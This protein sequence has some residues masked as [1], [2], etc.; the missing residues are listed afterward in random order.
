MLGN[1]RDQLVVA[2]LFVGRHLL[3]VATQEAVA[4]GARVSAVETALM[5]ALMAFP[6][7]SQTD[8]VRIVGRDKTTLSRTIARL[9]KEGMITDR[10][11][12]V[13]G[14]RKT[15][16]L[17]EQARNLVVPALHAVSERLE[18][19][20]SDLSSEQESAF[21]KMVDALMKS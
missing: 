17:T 3:E 5:L 13:D 15:L 4:D 9:E 18:D 1:S 16:E 19:A 11:D 6:D 2:L 10:I 14:R 21:L 12:P 20:I 8:L 7:S